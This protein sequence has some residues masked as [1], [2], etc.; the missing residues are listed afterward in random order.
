MQK[1]PFHLYLTCLNITPIYFTIS[2]YYFWK[3]NFN[4]DVEFPMELGKLCNEAL[5]AKFT[6]N[7]DI[8]K[9]ADQTKTLIG[10]DSGPSATALFDLTVYL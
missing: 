8:V 9:S 6:T 10:T 7:R 3:I 1:F 4:K 5:D 2:L